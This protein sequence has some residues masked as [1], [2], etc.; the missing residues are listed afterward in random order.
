M[1]IENL[2]TRNRILITAVKPARFPRWSV[3][4]GCRY[5]MEKKFL[6]GSRG[7]GHKK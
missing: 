1:G 4:T 3:M 6:P 7:G 2:T 5:S